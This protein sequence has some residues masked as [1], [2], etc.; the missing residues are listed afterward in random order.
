MS[1]GLE[2]HLVRQMTEVDEQKSPS[3][4]KVVPL[5]ILKIQQGAIL[6][7]ASSLDGAGGEVIR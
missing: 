3:E 1:L 2:N 7:C 5:A 4:A 6:V